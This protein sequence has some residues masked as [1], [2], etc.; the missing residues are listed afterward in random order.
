M[1]TTTQY[2][3]DGIEEIN[4]QDMMDVHGGFAPFIFPIV[5]AAG[6]FGGSGITA[7]AAAIAGFTL[8][9]AYGAVGGLLLAGTEK[10]THQ[11]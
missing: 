3:F 9:V 5:A 4:E 6:G 1:S 7:G 2:Q 11:H 10:N 8:G